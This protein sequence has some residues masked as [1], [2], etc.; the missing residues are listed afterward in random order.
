MEIESGKTA[1]LEPT[2]T[3]A[4]LYEKQGF[5]NKALEIYR[6]LIALEPERDD[7]RQALKGLEKRL[8]E[9]TGDS[10]KLRAAKILSELELWKEAIS[11]R[12]KMLHPG[13]EKEKKILVIYGNCRNSGTGQEQSLF[14][15]VSFEEI[16]KEIR[17]TARE[18]GMK[19]DTFQS[20]DEGKL[21]EQIRD[22]GDSY[23][24]LI[25]DP[26][27]YTYTSVLI[28]DALLK[29][30]A[31]VIEVHVSNINRQGAFGKKPLITGA[32]TAQLA[33]FGKE[34]YTMAV[35]AA[36]NMSGEETRLQYK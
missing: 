4:R 26:G 21:A 10:S 28:R 13:P 24:V 23:D 22:A 14:A 9:N 30:S 29:V 32:V 31:P 35:H 6:E 25:I 16:E 11:K 17:A 8:G 7:L 36:A 15:H 34:T 33:G 20:G 1:E 19:A 18:L 3:L 12:K 5:L 27:A 2:V